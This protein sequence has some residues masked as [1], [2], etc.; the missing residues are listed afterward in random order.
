LCRSRPGRGRGGSLGLG[1]FEEIIAARSC[2]Q[3]DREKR[4]IEG[5]KAP[6]TP[7]PLATWAFSN[8]RLR[9]VA[10]VGIAVKC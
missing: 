6:F 1:G 10:D 5:G 3:E 4:D 2:F 9:P 7:L 8:D